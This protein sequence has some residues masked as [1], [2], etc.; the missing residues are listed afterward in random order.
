MPVIGFL[1]AR[2]HAD[3]TG[4]LVRSEGSRPRQVMS[5]ARMSRSNTALPRAGTSGWQGWRQIWLAVR[6]W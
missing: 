5:T 2:S 6:W 1:S 4:L 3:S